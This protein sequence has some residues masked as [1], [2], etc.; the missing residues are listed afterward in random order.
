V[1]NATIS[2]IRTYVAQRM[3]AQVTERAVDSTNHARSICDQGEDALLEGTTLFVDIRQSSNITNHVRNE[4]AARMYESYF[5]GAV[6][7]VE[8]N[9]GHVVSFNG[10]GMLAIFPTMPKSQAR[11]EDVRDAVRASLQIDWFVEHI[12]GPNFSHHFTMRPD[13]TGRPLKFAVGCGIDSGEMRVV[14]I[15]YGPTWDVAWVGRCTNTSAKLSSVLSWPEN[16]G[17]TGTCW[18]LLG[19]R[20]F[21]SSRSSEQLWG[22]ASPQHFGGNVRQIRTT[23]FQLDLTP[24]SLPTL[25]K[26]SRNPEPL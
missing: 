13:S 12:L 23:R 4:V 9:G 16:I 18:Q 19:S 24:G 7:I 10:D 11:A 17:I 20:E 6:Q 5:F 25:K 8:G 21:G 3:A 26:T 2:S 22:K 14:R 1:T 15:G